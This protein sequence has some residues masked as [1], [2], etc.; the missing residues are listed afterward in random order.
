MARVL[1]ELVRWSARSFRCVRLRPDLPLQVVADADV[2]LQFRCRLAYGCNV[3]QHTFA[4]DSRNR[5]GSTGSYLST[6]SRFAARYRS[7]DRLDHRQV[8]SLRRR[9]E[10]AHRLDNHLSAARATENDSERSPEV[11]CHRK[12]DRHGHGLTLARLGTVRK[13]KAKVEPDITRDQGRISA[14]RINLGCSAQAASR[15]CAYHSFRVYELPRF[16][17]SGERSI[18]IRFPVRLATSRYA[19]ATRAR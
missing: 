2:P 4:L 17:K 13:E 1:S 8:V 14:N 9:S 15:P 3:T 10:T 16:R 7:R 19:C 5:Y 12:N 18:R 6:L 11:I